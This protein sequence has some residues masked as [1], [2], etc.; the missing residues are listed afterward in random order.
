MSQKIDSINK[1]RSTEPWRDQVAQWLLMFEECVSSAKP[2]TVRD[3]FHE[4]CHWRDL[5]AITWR[6]KTVSG[7]PN[8]LSMIQSLTAETQ[9]YGLQLPQ[10]HAAPRSVI[11]AGVEAIEAIFCFETRVGRSLGVI[12]LTPVTKNSDQFKAC[13]LY[14]SPSPRD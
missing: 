13:L 14:T 9:P 12:R 11:R 8:I 7:L 10:D 6:V 5:L 2:D 4:D 1:S 3:L